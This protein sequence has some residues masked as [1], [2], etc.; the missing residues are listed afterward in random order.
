[1]TAYILTLKLK[2][3]LKEKSDVLKILALCNQSEAIEILKTI[4]ADKYLFLCPVK[5]RQSQLPKGF[6]IGKNVTS[7][8]H[9]AMK[10]GLYFPKINWN[11]IE[12]L[13]GDLIERMSICQ[14]ETMRMVERIGKAVSGTYTSRLNYYYNNLRYWNH[15]IK[16]EKIDVFYRCAPPHEGYDNV[17]A[18]LCKEHNVTTFYSNPFH[19]FK[20][21]YRYFAKDVRNNFPDFYLQNIKDEINPDLIDLLNV[22]WEKKRPTVPPVVIPA[23][24]LKIQKRYLTLKKPILAYYQ[25]KC[26]IVN[27]NQKY[28]YFPLHFQYEATTCPMGG[29]FVDQFLAIELLSCLNIPIYVKE[30]PRISKNRSIGYYE[31]IL[32]IKNVKLISQKEDN[33][34]LIDNSFFVAN[35][36]GTAGWEA[37]LRG[38]PSIIFGYIFYQK[39]P[40]VFQIKNKESLNNAIEKINYFVPDKTDVENFLRKLQNYLFIHTTKDIILALKKEIDKLESPIDKEWSEFDGL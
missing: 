35:I 18:Y 26:S 28:I 3:L 9:R 2:I 5:I 25:K 32:K 38:K 21:K 15:I 19:T 12:P 14:I 6:K 16:K 30:H 8:S 17:I 27:Y 34:K 13:S 36:T 40:G 37:V 33:Y 10:K 1:M 7:Y 11:D 29:P 4:K 31:R 23:K 20:N 24:K 39:A 22:H